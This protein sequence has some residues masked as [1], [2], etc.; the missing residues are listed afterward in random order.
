MGP[1]QVHVDVT[2]HWRETA[3]WSKRSLSCGFP[4]LLGLDDQILMLRGVRGATVV[5]TAFGSAQAILMRLKGFWREGR[6]KG[7][8]SSCSVRAVV[9]VSTLFFLSALTR[10]LMFPK[11]WD[12]SFLEAL[13]AV[14]DDIVLKFIWWRRD[15]VKDFCPIV[16]LGDPDLQAMLSLHGLNEESPPSGPPP[17][18][19]ARLLALLRGHL[20]TLPGPHVQWALLATV[21]TICVLKCLL[22]RGPGGR[23]CAAPPVEPKSKKA[24]TPAVPASKAPAGPPPA[25]VERRPEV[26]RSPRRRK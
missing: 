12:R 24:K 19:L 20:E 6:P 11:T 15:F 10:T 4:L 25:A 3:A 16:Y 2:S 22:S 14:G 7:F 21:A 18:P 17:S 26:E 9:F 1:D 13:S 5:M 8:N 23:A